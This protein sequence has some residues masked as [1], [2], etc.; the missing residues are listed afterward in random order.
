MCGRMHLRSAPKRPHLD[1]LLKNAKKRFDHMSQQEKNSM[2][3]C[4]AI[5]WSI[6]ELLFPETAESA[7]L[8]RAR[9]RV[10][11]SLL[12]AIESGQ[13]L[14][15]DLILSGYI[16]LLISRDRKFLFSSIKRR[17]TKLEAA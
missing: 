8:R 16:A 14:D 9:V 5:G 13:P 12:A 10:V 6:S 15:G 17:L 11:K 7:K 2:F 4:Q 3:A 1:K